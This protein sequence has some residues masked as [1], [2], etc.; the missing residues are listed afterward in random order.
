MSLDETQ[1][2]A[3][4][5]KFYFGSQPEKAEDAKEDAV[6]AEAAPIDGSS[7][8]AEAAKAEVA[9]AVIGEEE[10]EAAADEAAGAAIEANGESVE[11]GTATAAA[12]GEAVP[13]VPLSAAAGSADVAT[14]AKGFA[15]KT[16]VWI[17]LAIAALVIGLLVGIFAFGGA[18]AA[19]GGSFG[20]KTAVAES[21][22]DKPIATYTY[23]GK[24]HTL[25]VREVIQ[26]QTSLVAAKD[27]SGN[28]ALPSADAV[29]SAA[30]NEVIIATAEEKGISATDEEVA[31]FAKE[32]VGS[33]DY[34][35]I[36]AN[37]NMEES[38]VKE[39]LRNS[40]LMN[41]LRESVV[42]STASTA[43][44][45]QAPPEPTAKASSSSSAN[46]DEDDY[47]YYGEEESDDEGTETPDKDVLTEEYARYIIALAGDEWDASADKWA[48]TDGPYASALAKYDI[49]SKGAS[50][51]AA[52]VA[53]SVAYQLYTEEA[54]L[55][56]TAWNDFVNE[57]LSN[58]T[59]DVYTL[60]A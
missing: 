30:R 10:T 2:S 29:L 12:D 27:A 25:T 5:S 19:K 53:Y 4:K 23:K 57:S 58:S 37:Y 38:A 21:D 42:G 36:A 51:E 46:G 35:S 16:P 9:E 13:M 39:L 22:L 20:G 15:L 40:C 55:G 54:S 49:S 60:I 28:Y 56:S 52:S 45:P 50:Y 44:M 18:G 7:E 34:A 14:A 33:G 59:I 11:A 47:N 32:T 43:T 17:A 48:S 3:P 31:A 1:N 26:Q 41:K 6:A 24:S 8:G